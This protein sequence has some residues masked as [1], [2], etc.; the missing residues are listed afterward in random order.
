MQGALLAVTPA[1]PASP[2]SGVTGPGGTNGGAGPGSGGTGGGAGPGSGVGGSGGSGGT[3]GQATV[4]VIDPSSDTV[5]PSTIPVAV[6]VFVMAVS[7]QSA[8]G[9]GVSCEHA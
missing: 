8:P 3:S 9:A 5:D 7:S 1:E 6:A 2:A 4:V